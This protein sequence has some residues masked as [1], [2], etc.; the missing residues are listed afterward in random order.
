MCCNLVELLACGHDGKN[1]G[2]EICTFQNLMQIERRKGTP[3]TAHIMIEY[4]I[5]CNKSPAERRVVTDEI[6]NYCR[7]YESGE[8]GANEDRRLRTP[9][10]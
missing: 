8:R 2:W 10:I 9:A 6:C 1:L 4:E 3:E 7:L 5:I